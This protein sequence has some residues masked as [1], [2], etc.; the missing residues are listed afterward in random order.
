MLIKAEAGGG[1]RGAGRG[2]KLKQSP[3]F[4]FLGSHFSTFNYNRVQ[5]TTSGDDA[6]TTAMM[7]DDRTTRGR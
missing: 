3:E 7:R 6:Y 1:C 4:F 5:N 2:L